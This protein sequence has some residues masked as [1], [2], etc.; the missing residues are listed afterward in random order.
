MNGEMIVCVPGTWESR[1]AFLEAIVTTTSGEFMFAGM[2]L[3]HPKGKDHVELEFAEPYHQMA[4]AFSYA[5]QGKLSDETLHKIAQHRSVIYLHFPLDIASQR[6]RLVRFTEVI[7]RCGGIAVK[8]ENSGIAHEW[9]RWFS[10]LRSDSPFDTYCASVVLT[11]DERYYYSCGM[12]G[13]GLPDAQISR[14]FDIQ[15]AADL[16]NQFNYYQI[17]EKPSL[18][19]GH[20]FSLTADS[21]RF[22]IESL[23]DERHPDDDLFHNPHGLW[24]LTRV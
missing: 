4:E 20:T 19:S 6:L 11:G 2:I 13:F 7:S 9:E 18:E 3:A 23:T 10:L 1:K 21:P 5:G 22:R 24:N 14:S 16:L 15:E 8:L 12:H 17:V